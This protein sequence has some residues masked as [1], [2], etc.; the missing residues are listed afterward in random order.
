M[1]AWTATT[2]KDTGGA[3]YENAP[4]GNHPAVL[5]AII[6]LG[7]QE[8]NFTPGETKLQHRCFWVWELVG[9]RKKDG[10]PFTAGMELT[11]SMHEKS[12]MRKF[13]QARTGTTLPDSIDYD[14]TQELGQP[15]LL[16]MIATKNGDKEYVNVDGPSGLVTGMPVPVATLPKFAWNIA[17][18]KAGTPISFPEWVPFS[19]GTSIED[20]VCDSAEL[21]GKAKSARSASTSGAS[22][23]GTGSTTMSPPAGSAVPARRSDPSSPQYSQAPPEDMFAVEHPDFSATEFYPRSKIQDWFVHH[24]DAKPDAIYVVKQG[25]NASDWVLANLVGFKG[26]PF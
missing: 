1:G 23:A 17:D 14:I 26:Q 7:T 4:A 12:K 21:K 20:I 9:S 13:V 22:P 3:D 6:D 10:K 16:R 25:G 19:Y 5:V 24:Q 18:W 8:N 2:K 15:C 11:F